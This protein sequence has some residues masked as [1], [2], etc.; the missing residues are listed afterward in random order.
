MMYL[1]KDEELL[2]KK[3]AIELFETKQIDEFEVGTAK[4][5]MQ[6]HKFLFQDVFEFAGE[7]RNVNI[8]KGQFRFASVLYLKEN[9]KI[10]EKMPENNFDEIIEKYV[11]MN[12][13]H[14]FREGNGRT[15]RIWL[16]QMLKKNIKK[17][18]DWSNIDRFEYLSAMERSPV[19]TLEIKTL[20]KNNLSDKIDDK[21]T[22]ISGIQQSYY[23]E[24]M[25]KFDINEIQKE[26]D[27]VPFCFLFTC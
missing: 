24:N 2:S 3:R 5:L 16:D 25:E 19:N 23:Y 21:F 26:L 15:M 27:W 10:V 20:I 11:E 4:G 9:L 17:C 12:I 6:I 13:I 8:S 14:P 1:N 22:Y 18:V 7:I